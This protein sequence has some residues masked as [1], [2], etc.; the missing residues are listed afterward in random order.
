[1]YKRLALL[2]V[3]ALLLVGCGSSSGSDASEGETLFNSATIGSDAG[4]VTCHSLEP[5][6]VIVGPSLAGIATDAAGDAADEGITTE[7]MLKIMITDPNAEVKEG[8]P[9]DTMPQDF[10]TQMTPQQLDDVIA[11][12]MTLK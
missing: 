5:D 4:C 9:A 1:M 2:F 6:K 7:A 10:A 3:V 11:Y 12:L 8:F